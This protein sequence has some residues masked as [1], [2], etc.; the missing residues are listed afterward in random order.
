MTFP[1]APSGTGAKT[2]LVVPFP[3][4]QQLASE[5]PVGVLQTQYH[6][7]SCFDS[8]LWSAWTTRGSSFAPSTYDFQ[9]FNSELMSSDDKGSLPTS[10][11]DTSP[12][13]SCQASSNRWLNVL[14]ISRIRLLLH[15]KRR[16]F[17]LFLQA[18]APQTLAVEEAPAYLLEAS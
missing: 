15:L 3:Q 13:V 7:G 10:C 18:Q 1:S 16:R 8:S 5:L 6:H 14:P 17:P 11:H 9:E 12:P 2:S 4:A